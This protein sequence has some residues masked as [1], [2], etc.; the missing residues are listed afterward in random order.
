MNDTLEMTEEEQI[1]MWRYDE[2]ERAGYEVRNAQRIARR[3]DVDLHKAV[4]LITKKGCDQEVAV[5]ILL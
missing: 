5:Q 4:D 3:H 2:L 1:V